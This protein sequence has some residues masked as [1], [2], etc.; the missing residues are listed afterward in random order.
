MPNLLLK[1]SW[2]KSKNKYSTNSFHRLNN[3]HLKT[4]RCQR[5]IYGNSQLRNCQRLCFKW[6]IIFKDFRKLTRKFANNFFR[7]LISSICLKRKEK[8]WWQNYKKRRVIPKNWNKPWLI[9]RLMQTMSWEN[10]KSLNA[11]SNRQKKSYKQCNPKSIG[12]IK[13]MIMKFRISIQ[14]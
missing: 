3:L 5:K 4:I 6:K 14:H 9:C 2:L 12:I 7:C 1:K 13:T 8:G 11:N 10:E